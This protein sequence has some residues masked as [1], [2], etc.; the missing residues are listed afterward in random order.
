MKNENPNTKLI[1]QIN[2][3]YENLLGY[4][5]KE[6]K[7]KEIE[8]SQWNSF[9]E[10][11]IPCEKKKFGGLYNVRNQ[12]AF[13]PSESPIALFHEYFGHGLFYEWSLIG[14][15]AIFLENMLLNDEKEKFQEKNFT[16]KDIKEFREKNKFAQEIDEFQKQNV[17][18]IESFAIFSEY[19]LSKKMKLERLF[20]R[21]YDSFPIK[22]KRI[23]EGVI[24]FNQNYGDLATFYNFGLARKTT[25]KRVKKLL[26][27][28]YGNK[29][30]NIKLATLYGSRKEFSD[31]D[32]CVISDNLPRIDSSWF[33][34]RIIPINEFENMINN[35]DVSL[36]GPI[37]NSEYLIGDKDYFEKNK[38]KFV[39]QPISKNIISYNLK[40]AKEQKKFG[41]SKEKKYGSDYRDSYL[42]NVLALSEGKRIF[43][44]EDFESYLKNVRFIE[45]KGG[46]IE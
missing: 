8:K 11:Y 20:E 13:I 14:K 3:Y 34:V 7:I 10:I 43:T 17:E 26:E 31:I 44:N 19:F 1:S 46:R 18:L 35:L 23:I 32:I 4:S 12:T 5:I 22:E 15:K 45:M 2:E 29:I 37:L 33:D 38:K 28:V 41:N 36:T 21:R 42:A 30:N 40:K 27:D 24:N 25:S 6:T 9:C 16:L 39:Y